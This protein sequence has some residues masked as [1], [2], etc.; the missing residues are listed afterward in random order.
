MNEFKNVLG[1]ALI[2]CSISPL[3]GFYRDGCCK[4]G[5]E[6]AGNHTVCAQITDEFL[7]YTKSK[8]NDLSTPIP[9]YQ[10][11]GLKEGDFWCLCALRWK[12][13]LMAG[14]APK[15]KLEATHEKTLEFISLE[16]LKKHATENVDR[17][18]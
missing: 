18:N 1:G 3:T 17:T 9:A 5:A 8:G 11:P 4:T 7:E 12:E 14:K 16:E 2:A 6:D 10:F 13:A 15:V